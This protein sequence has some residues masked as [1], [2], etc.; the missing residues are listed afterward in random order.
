MNHPLQCRCGRLRGFLAEPERGSH[1]VCY[2]K[3]CQTYAHVLGKAPEVLDEFGGTEVVATLA[4]RLAFTEG[5][6]ALACLSLS[7]RGILRWYA[8]CCGTPIGNTLRN[9]RL[10]YVSVVH[11]CLR[12]R[13]A[14]IERA[15]GPVRVRANTGS[16]RGRPPTAPVSTWVEAM[17]IATA[18]A[19]AR[20]SGRYR[21]TP[22]FTD[23]GVPLVPPRVLSRE[24]RDRARN[25]L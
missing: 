14:T 23:D 2:C 10:A 18:V 22:F 25:R 4:S 5:V 16:A 17:R 9:H 1:A 21:C 12:S 3:D 20:L 15:F 6:E 19:G 7:P 11:T 13:T 8:G 24:E